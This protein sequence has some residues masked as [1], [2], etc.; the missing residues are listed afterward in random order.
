[1]KLQ[2]LG[3]LIIFQFKV[4]AQDPKVILI[5]LD[6]FRPLEFFTG[7]D[8]LLLFNLKYTQNTSTVVDQ[9]W[10]S[11]P[12]IRVQKLLPFL[13]QLNNTTAIFLG[14]RDNGSLVAYSNAYKKSGPGYNEILSGLIKDRRVY[15]NQNKWNKNKTVFAAAAKDPR[16][17]DKVEAYTSWDFFPYV[18]N[19]KKNKIYVNAGNYP[20]LK[21]NPTQTQ[22]Q[23]LENQKKVTFIW[24]RV[25]FDAFTHQFAMDALRNSKPKLLLIGYGETDDYAHMQKYDAY[26]NSAHNND[27][28]IK[29]IWEFIQGDPF[30]KDQTTLIITTDHGRGYGTDWGSHK[31]KIKGSDEGWLVILGP[32]N[33]KFNPNDKGL[34]YVNQIAATIVTLMDLQYKPNGRI[35]ESL[36]K[37]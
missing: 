10:D 8:S 3:I 22:L 24:P 4:F 26:L 15:N 35:G 25:R 6:G 28:M 34:Y 16:Y 13:S 1:M 29:E 30:Y 21:T 11:N 2:L 20:V 14:N 7:A 36:I 18:L 27:N 37:K 5:T 31:P 12:N 17:K 9:F 23:I 19:T 32:G 33:L